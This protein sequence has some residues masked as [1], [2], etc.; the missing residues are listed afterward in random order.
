MEKQ[1]EKIITDAHEQ[2]EQTLKKTKE[3]LAKMR[4]GAE[5]T[6]VSLKNDRLHEGRASIEKEVE[7]ILKKAA[8]EGTTL[9]NSK[10]SEKEISDLLKSIF[11]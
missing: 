8:Q 5:E 7:L 10:L 2:A 9:K 4:A 3:N 11:D 6:A 1:A